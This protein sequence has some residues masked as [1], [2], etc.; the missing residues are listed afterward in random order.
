MIVSSYPTVCVCV[1]DSVQ[2]DFNL[3]EKRKIWHILTSMVDIWRVCAVVSNVEYWSSPITWT[4]FNVKHLKVCIYNTQSCTTYSLMWCMEKRKKTQVLLQSYAKTMKINPN[5]VDVIVFF[6]WWKNR[7]A[8]CFF[9]SPLNVVLIVCH[10]AVVISVIWFPW[11]MEKSDF[12]IFFNE[13][14]WNQWKFRRFNEFRLFS[15]GFL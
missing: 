3:K 2:I 7:W 12:A 9:S 14:S 5:S 13:I 6:D 15:L 8:V 10:I 1:F 11:L 4:W